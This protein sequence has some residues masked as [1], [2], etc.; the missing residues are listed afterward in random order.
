MLTTCSVRTSSSSG[1]AGFV[2]RTGH[3]QAHVRSL[4]GLAVVG[5]KGEDSPVLEGARH[6]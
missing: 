6:G 3:R 2:Q 1:T 4:M 5:K